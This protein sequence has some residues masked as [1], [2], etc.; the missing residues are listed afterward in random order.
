MK[1]KH[2]DAALIHEEIEYARKVRAEP[3]GIIFDATTREI[4]R[5]REIVLKNELKG[6]IPEPYRLWTADS[7]STREGR[8]ARRA[9]IFIWLAEVGKAR[10][11][12]KP[13]KLSIK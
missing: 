4:M 7:G 3:D 8:E 6:I 11:P 10:I 13:V 2:P 5:L 9:Q 12:R 1:T